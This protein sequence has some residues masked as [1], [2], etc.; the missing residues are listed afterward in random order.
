VCICVAIVL[1][2]APAAVYWARL[3]QPR[4]PTMTEV[5]SWLGRSRDQPP[6]TLATLV[7]RDFVTRTLTTP[8]PRWTES[9]P[10]AQPKARGGQ[11]TDDTREGWVSRYGNHCMFVHVR[12]LDFLDDLWGAVGRRGYW[13]IKQVK[14]AGT[15]DL[16]SFFWY[17]CF[18]HFWK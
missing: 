7:R 15:C 17:S 12:Y 1:A 9:A 18:T 3:C 10:T 6:P 8:S 13:V 11:G 16:R 14:A 4:S 5:Q 2:L